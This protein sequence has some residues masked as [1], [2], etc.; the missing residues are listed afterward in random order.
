[1]A[2]LCKVGLHK[3][4]KCGFRCS[5]DCHCKCE[6]CKATRHE[7]DGC[8]CKNPGC[9]E[10]RDEGHAWNGCKCTKC[11]TTRNEGHTW[12]GCKCATC[13]KTRDEAHAWDGCKCTKCGKTKD[14]SHKWEGCRCTT[15]GK[16]R[17]SEHLE[18][19]G[20]CQVCGKCMP[21]SAKPTAE[22]LMTELRQTLQC[23]YT[24]HARIGSPDVDVA[25]TSL[26][27]SVTLSTTAIQSQFR[28]LLGNYIRY[29]LP[30]NREQ[31]RYLGEILKGLGFDSRQV[32]SL[33]STL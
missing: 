30:S 11:G 26:S 17:D 24:S 10:T 18:R 19:Q 4:R 22:I 3:W 15:C 28:K 5:N 14:E 21:A 12:D 1:M 20:V 29:E 8:I 16:T 25:V 27:R 9:K 6:R 2:I 13:G 33:L 31:F 23:L 7:W 32:D